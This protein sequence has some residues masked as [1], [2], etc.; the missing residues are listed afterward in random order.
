MRDVFRLVVTSC[1]RSRECA[2]EVSRLRLRARGG[3]RPGAQAVDAE[4]PLSEV[5]SVAKQKA[6]GMES[7]AES[8]LRELSVRL[9]PSE[10]G[11]SEEERARRV[12][13]V[14]PRSVRMCGCWLPLSCCHAYSSA[15]VFPLSTSISV[16]VRLRRVQCVRACCACPP[17][18]VQQ[19]V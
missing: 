19:L 4:G 12:S 14:S 5:L 15:V 11:L 13:E 9:G 8:A 16:C 18:L 2:T 10:E 3:G 1:E 17:C 7:T 6:N